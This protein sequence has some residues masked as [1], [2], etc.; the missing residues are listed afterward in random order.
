MSLG[1][2]CVCPLCRCYAKESHCQSPQTVSETDSV[3]AQCVVCCG[4]SNHSLHKCKC[5]YTVK[6]KKRL[7]QSKPDVVKQQCC[8]AKCSRV[9]SQTKLHL[10]IKQFKEDLLS[11]VKGAYVIWGNGF[12]ISSNMWLSHFW[13]HAKQTR[14]QRLTS[15][16]S[17]FCGTYNVRGLNWEIS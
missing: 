2:H 14:K 7:K 6:K 5:Q 9:E 15:L 12:N 11:A 1:A 3:Q 17:R 10:T 4:L 13:P 8:L 16:I